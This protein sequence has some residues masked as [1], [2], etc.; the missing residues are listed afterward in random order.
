MYADDIVTRIALLLQK[1]QEFL[2]GPGVGRAC[3]FSATDSFALVLLRR[4]GASAS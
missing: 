3:D 4:H 1:M 2:E